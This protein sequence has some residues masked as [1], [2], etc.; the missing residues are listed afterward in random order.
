[1]TAAGVF[2]HLEELHS[3]TDGVAA[4]CERGAT[5]C[6]QAIYLGGMLAQT[7]STRSTTS[8]SRTGTST[9]FEQLLEP[10]ELEVHI[11][12]RRPD[13]R[14][15]AGAAHRQPRDAACGAGRSVDFRER[16]RGR[17]A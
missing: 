14:R 8:T 15:L 11:L 12:S 3:A 9:S 2:F 7:R 13:P 1:M 4:L 6:V 5:F 16:E 17:R 10:H